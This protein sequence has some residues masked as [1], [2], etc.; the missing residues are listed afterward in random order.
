MIENKSQVLIE[1]EKQANPERRVSPLKRLKFDLFQ[2]LARN[3]QNCSK[4]VISVEVLI[5]KKES[6]EL[7]IHLINE[8]LTQGKL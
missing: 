1:S 2:E 5:A 3:N 8:Q 6:I 7:A 4:G